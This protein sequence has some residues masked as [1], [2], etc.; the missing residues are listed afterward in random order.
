MTYW[1]LETHPDS[2]DLYSEL[3]P[4]TRASRTD[5]E[6]L[7]KTLKRMEMECKNAWDYLKIINKYDEQREGQEQTAANSFS[8]MPEFLND[9][10]QRIMVMTS[11]HE[12]VTKRFM[13]LLE[14]MGN[15]H[16]FPEN[17]YKVHHTCKILSEFSL[18]YRTTRERVI[19]TIQKKKMNREK[20]RQAMKQWMAAEKGS[21]EESRKRHHR[22]RHH[23]HGEE[24]ELQRILGND[25][26]ITENGT[27]RR[28]KKHHH[29]KEQS[30]QTSGG[31]EGISTKPAR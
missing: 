20:K 26:D 16:P 7:Q 10:A 4:L 8:K 14:W 5:F 22:H 27:L 11:I 21:E 6:E 17:D 3:G 13:E 28:R 9:A 29:R 15:P 1:V 24:S 30:A 18:E 2:S 31:R 23:Q 25:I 19:Q 12:K